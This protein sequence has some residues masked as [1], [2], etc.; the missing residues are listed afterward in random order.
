MAKLKEDLPLLIPIALLFL[1][2][3]L[4]SSYLVYYQLTTPLPVT[5]TPLPTP[6]MTPTPLIE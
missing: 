5:P 2:G 4:L 1:L 3:G 6:T